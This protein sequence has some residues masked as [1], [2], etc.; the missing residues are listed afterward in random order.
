MEQT[1]IKKVIA[2]DEH[3]FRVL[4]E[5]YRNL[6]FHLVYGVLRNQKDAED[7]TQEV[8]LKIYLSLPEYKNQGFKSWMTRIAVNHAIDMSRKVYRKRE[9]VAEDFQLDMNESAEES[10]GEQVVKKEIK[11]LVLQKIHELPANYRDT[12][13]GFYI[14]DKTYEQMA[15][16][17]QVK[18]ATIATK[19]HRARIWMKSN[20]K[21]SD[22]L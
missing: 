10:V 9:V 8:F 5:T 18:R 11:Q 20:W 2:G 21:E 16:E 7:A 3:A 15:K 14:E 17:Q 22:F 4:V 12:V 6:V 1:L 19:L 13:Y